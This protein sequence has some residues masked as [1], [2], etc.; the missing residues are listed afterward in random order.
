MNIF[1]FALKMELDGEQFYLQQAE[2][3]NY[4]ELKVVLKGL[5][6]DERRHYKIVQQ[7]QNQKKEYIEPDPAIS[8][9]RNVFEL[10]RNKPFIPK[11]Q[12]SIA[13]LKDE[14]RDVY[15]A[16][17]H[18]EEASVHLYKEL[19][20][21]VESPAEKDILEK[22]VQEEEKHAEVIGN[23]IQLLNNFNEWVESAE[24]HH[25]KPY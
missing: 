13:K 8:A 24:F 25:Q 19:R 22:L 1:D 15:Q 12:D 21:T 17:L 5:A 6:D 2:K 23:I 20:K 11:D 10:A 18:K 3:V 7:L 16:A 14:Q 4:A 9:A